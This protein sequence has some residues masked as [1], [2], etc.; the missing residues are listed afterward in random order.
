[1][2]CPTVR[3]KLS[4]YLEAEVSSGARVAIAA[5]L[6]ECA[7]CRAEAAALQRAQAA[8]GTLAAVERAPDLTADV[9]R[10]LAAGP[11]RRLGWRWAGA[12]LSAAAVAAV[13]LL[14]LGPRTLPVRPRARPTRVAE[15]SPR[16]APP[17][18]SAVVTSPKQPT[19]RQRRLVRRHIARYSPRPL[20]PAPQGATPAPPVRETPV[21][22]AARQPT[23]GGV[24]LLVGEPRETAPRSS[25]YLEVS[26]PDG[27]KSVTERAVERDADGQPRTVRIAYQR[28]APETRAATEGG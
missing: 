1:M 9:R 14:W 18:P 12:A 16:V 15:A 4:R 8:L 19:P 6:E 2:K 3:R 25:C 28:T 7:D 20:L 24:V 21:D 27:S 17:A 23:I 11:P 26:L 5:H 10:R 13:L 22:V